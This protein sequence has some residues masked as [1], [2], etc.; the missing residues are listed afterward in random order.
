MIKRID[1]ENVWDKLKND[2]KPVIIYGMGNAAD[3]I[4]DILEEKGIAVSDIFA[5]DE[6]VRGHSFRGMKVK[7][8]SDICDEYS[9][10]NVVLAF[11]SHL[12]DVLKNIKRINDEHTVYAPDI[13]VAGNGLFTREFVAE[14]DEEF[15]FVYN[16]LGDEESR[17]VYLDVIR[18]KVSGKVEYLYNCFCNKNSVYS[19]ILKLTDNEFIV[20][21][22][23]YDGDTIR[24]FT[25]YTQGKYNGIIAMEPD[26]KN[27]RKLKRNTDGMQ[28]VRL[29][30]IAAWNK[31]E[32]L[33]FA[34]TSARSAH[35]AKS[36][37]EVDACDLD[38][39]AENE[40][41]TLIKMDIEGC[42]KAALCGAEKTIRRCHP[43]LYV[44][45]YHRN[46]DLFE[47]P[48]KILEL[49]D[50]YKLYFR[51]SVY[52]PAWESNFYCV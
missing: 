26:E 36:G 38:S 51:H 39:L 35:I 3:R 6:F 49:D 19:E 33:S 32:K 47:L 5:S 15:D 34:D 30:N 22:G 50:S 18:Y 20:D 10:F 17:R 8:Y 52:I 23:A 27:F 48:K 43:K 46:E 25:A 16:R 42:E 28:G 7:K 44:C 1:D 4:I 12:D 37:N 9:D 14:H 40:N 31:K 11:A 41:I 24:E 2:G 21:M 13:P 45:A 29:Y